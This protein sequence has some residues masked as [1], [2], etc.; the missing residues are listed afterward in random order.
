MAQQGFS[1]RSIA[2]GIL[3]GLA[4]ARRGECDLAPIHLLDEATGIYNTPFLSE[5]LELC[6]GW[7]RMQGIVFR[8]GDARFEGLTGGA[9]DAA[10]R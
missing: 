4:A 2:V 9:G 8:K 10:L 1:V 7:R 3:G 6:R 5:G